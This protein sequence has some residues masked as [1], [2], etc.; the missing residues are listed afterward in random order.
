MP[1]YQLNEQDVSTL[2][3]L[4][5]S[6]T[7]HR[8][9]NINVDDS[10]ESDTLADYRLPIVA[11][12]ANAVQGEDENCY[13]HGMDDFLVKPVSIK[14]IVLTLE[15]WLPSLH[16]ISNKETI[17]PQAQATSSSQDANDFS[18]LFQGIDESFESSEH[19][20]NGEIATTA[21][22][23]ENNANIIDFK[24][25]NE[26]FGDADVAMSLLEEF[27]TSFVEDWE[28]IN[29]LWEEQK[30]KSLKTTAHRVKGAAKMVA[31]DAFATPLA[32]IE[33]L[34]S[35]LALQTLEVSS[36][37]SQMI[38]YLQ[39]VEAVSMQFQQELNQIRHILSRDLQ[40]KA[41][42]YE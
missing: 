24:A 33:S 7:A 19:P 40:S 20:T 29:Q 42:S 11:L 6:F 4:G 22:T 25:L 15:K 27:E 23:S 28:A 21:S 14:Q 37:Q 1:G 35:E 5:E 31:C 36:A 2:S 9:N 3:S 39:E 38:F 16:D 13:A 17:A 18:A 34:G 12:T 8:L 32:G 10:P 30:F 41:Y 26:L